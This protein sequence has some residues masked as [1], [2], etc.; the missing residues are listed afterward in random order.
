MP[1]AVQDCKK[2]DDANS[3]PSA[4][5]NNVAISNSRSIRQKLQ[6]IIFDDHWRSFSDLERYQFYTFC[7]FSMVITMIQSS[8]IPLALMFAG[9]SLRM[10]Q[11]IPTIQS[12]ASQAMNTIQHYQ[13]GLVYMSA[14]FHYLLQIRRDGGPWHIGYLIFIV[15]MSDTGALILGRS[16]KKK[17]T[18]NNPSTS[19]K[20]PNGFFISFLKSVSPGKTI[21][22]LVGAVLTGPMS[23]LMYPIDLSS[24]AAESNTS[25]LHISNPTI[26]KVI[27]GLILSIVGIIGDLAESSVKRM[28]GKK[29]SGGLLPGHGGV[30]DRFDSL[31]T[32]GIV[33]YCWVLG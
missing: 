4:A 13:F 25:F 2:N 31:F 9:I 21:P 30:V 29:D 10:V 6:S 28:S 15:W 11:Y 22:G 8:L 12:S 20:Q 23:A 19:S 1:S 16:M 32:A 27:L 18:E 7:F 17:T 5:R 3:T 26:Q 33:Y 24:S 14:G